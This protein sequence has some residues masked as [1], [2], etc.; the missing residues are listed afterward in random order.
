MCEAYSSVYRVRE[1][2]GGR[3]SIAD[4][5]YHPIRVMTMLAHNADFVD[6]IIV[7]NT[8][9]TA[10]AWKKDHVLFESAMCTCVLGLT[11]RYMMDAAQA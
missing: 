11:F 4:V 2:P 6:L 7:L 10:N 5:R 1:M 8:A 3:D 9:V